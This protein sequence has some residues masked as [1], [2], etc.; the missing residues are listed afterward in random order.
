MTQQD[1]SPKRQTSWWPF[2]RK[3][4]KKTADGFEIADWAWEGAFEEE[5]TIDRDAY[6]KRYKP[7][8]K[9]AYDGA[10]LNPPAEAEAP[11]E[12]ENDLKDAI[13]A[14][15]QRQIGKRLSALG[16]KEAE[17]EKTTIDNPELE[18]RKIKEDLTG[19][20]I[21]RIVDEAQPSLLEKKIAAGYA[22]RSYQLFKTRHRRLEEPSE[23]R[24]IQFIIIIV[25]LMI[26]AEGFVNLWFFRGS[27]ET[28]ALGASVITFS[29]A[30]VNVA[31]GML[32]GHTLGKATHYIP[33][34]WVRKTLGWIGSI[35]FFLAITSLHLGFGVYRNI[36][37]ENQSTDG[38]AGELVP[39]IQT[40]LSEGNWLALFAGEGTLLAVVGIAF[41]A[42]AFYEGMAAI[43][44]KYPGYAS[45]KKRTNRRLE[46]FE[47]GWNDTKDD[48]EDAFEDAVEDLEDIL[49]ENERK[50]TGFKKRSRE[51]T[52]LAT[53]HSREI[54]RAEMIFQ[55]LIKA[56]RDANKAH[57][58]GV[59]TPTFFDVP[60]IMLEHLPGYD[61]VQLDEAQRLL[62][63]DFEA[64]KAQILDAKVDIENQ[65][66][67]EFK[68]LAKRLAEIEG[69]ARDRITEVL[70][71]LETGTSGKIEF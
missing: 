13:D 15:M 26:L 57:R 55:S 3:T 62:V 66:Q 48:I 22:E 19:I 4:T 44:D 31:V 69:K 2:K 46:A 7:E 11:S 51:F 64:A 33:K 61:G 35:L 58:N 60:P 53:I 25:G 37:D 32:A 12:F 43:S 28:G 29:V 14:D 30:A 70:P 27:L 8:E 10:A 21:P 52:Q 36:V 65:K 40:I 49:D 54:A 20:E 39:R 18:I 6:I 71:T 47:N 1:S 45:I 17:L 63:Q 24:K 41:A 50:L 16:R 38:A 56:Y 5:F 42:I 9:G 59:P 68:A 23:G 34:F 67:M